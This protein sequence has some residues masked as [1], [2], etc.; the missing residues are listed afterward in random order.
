[1]YTVMSRKYSTPAYRPI[2]TSVFL[3]LGL[4]AIVPVAH[5]WAMYGVSE[6]LIPS[7]LRNGTSDD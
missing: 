3:A 7:S 4:S 2:R 1:M 6:E 5:I